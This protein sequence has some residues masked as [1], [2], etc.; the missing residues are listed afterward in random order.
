MIGA[1]AWLADEAAIGALL[2]VV[3]DRFDSKPGEQRARA[4]VLRVS[5]HL[6]TLDRNDAAADQ[7]WDWVEELQRLGV[8]SIRRGRRGAYDSPWENARLAFDASCESRLREWLARPRE[9]SALQRWR[10]AVQA[11][12]G[13]FPGDPAALSSRRIHVAGRTPEEVVA[14]LAGLARIGQPATLRQLSTHAFWGESK[15]LDDR[16]EL[17]ATLFPKLPLRERAIVV[18]VYL[19]EQFDGVLFIEN[20]DTYTSALAGELPAAHQHALVYVAGFRGAALRIRTEAGA[21]LHFTGPGAVSGIE[22]F[23]RWW[24]GAG[25]GDGIPVPAQGWSVLQGLSCAFWGD[26]DFAGMQILKSLR[27]RFGDVVAWRPGYEPMLRELRAAGRALPRSWESTE[28]QAARQVD[29]GRTG[30]RFADNE[31]LPAIRRCGFWHQERLAVAVGAGTT[32]S[33]SE[34]R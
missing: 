33:T 4:V 26:L 32:V 13:Q 27:E 25:P 19:P 22:A 16:S 11:H 29:P 18:A 6:P 15:L 10:A 20:Q 28:Q 5:E 23:K 30:C 7:T 12:A 9:A 2:G 14:A 8:L 1:P 3:L 21:C 24:F 17:I 31:L 34:S